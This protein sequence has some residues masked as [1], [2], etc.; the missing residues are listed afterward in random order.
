MHYLTLGLVGGNVQFWQ[1]TLSTACSRFNTI[2]MVFVLLVAWWWMLTKARRLKMRDVGWCFLASLH[3]AFST[4]LPLFMLHPVT[5]ELQQVGIR[6]NELQNIRDRAPHT[7]C[8]HTKAI[9]SVS[10]PLEAAISAR[11]AGVVRAFL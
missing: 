6:V 8:I 2:D 3:V 10:L 4:A 5:G 11:M 7:G 1:D 9:S